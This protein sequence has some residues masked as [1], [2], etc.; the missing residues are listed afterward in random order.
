MT[1]NFKLLLKYLPIIFVVFI[2]ILFGQGNSDIKNRR[3]L[4][5]SE[6]QIGELIYPSIVD[7]QSNINTKNLLGQKYVLQFLATWCGYCMK[8]HRMFMQMKTKLPVYAIGWRDDTDDLK[9]LLSKGNPYLNVG[10]DTYGTI[11]SKLDIRVIPQT[12][13]IDEK[14]QII[15][16][17][18]GAFDPN[19]LVKFFK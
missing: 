17:K 15:F 7:G 9:R 10:I 8:E 11:S 18:I 4:S 12:F 16:H 14:G 1:A 6:T 3:I 13:I 5:D 19:E 2:L